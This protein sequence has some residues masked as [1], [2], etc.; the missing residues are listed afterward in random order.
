MIVERIIW[1][2]LYSEKFT[3]SMCVATG[4]GCRDGGGGWE[5]VHIQPSESAPAVSQKYSDV[6]C[7][8]MF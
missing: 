3:E 6:P 4:G 1:T 2:C 8:D 7:F 5:G